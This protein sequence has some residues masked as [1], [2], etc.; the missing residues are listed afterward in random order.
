M[1]AGEG[2]TVKFS[3]W[4]LLI[5]RRFRPLVTTIC[6]SFS[7]PNLLPQHCSV[8]LKGIIRWEIK[9][10]ETQTWPH[11]NQQN[12]GFC[13]HRTPEATTSLKL[14]FGVTRLLPQAGKRVNSPQDPQTCWVRHGQAQQHHSWLPTRAWPQWPRAAGHSLEWERRALSAERQPQPHPRDRWE[15]SSLNKH[16]PLGKDMKEQEASLSAMTHTQNYPKEKALLILMGAQL[17]V[18]ASE[19]AKTQHSGPFFPFYSQI[20]RM[21]KGHLGKSRFVFS[22]SFVSK[23]NSNVLG[24]EER[25]E[26]RKDFPDSYE[27]HS[28]SMNTM[29]KIKIFKKV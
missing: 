6:E 19:T 3:M 17:P 11:G 14:V 12:P 5:R 10:W 24:E 25:I 9:A 28:S 1:E 27:K 15:G 29:M 21:R 13:F 2:A 4:K 8:V 18:T 20:F 7:N 23:W 22:S 16:G 26:G